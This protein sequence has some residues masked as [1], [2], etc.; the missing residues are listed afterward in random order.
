MTATRSAICAATPRSCVTKMMVMPNS[1]RS[2]RS[3][4]QIPGSARSRRGQWLAR[5][6]AAI[7]G[8]QERASAII[9]RWPK[10][11]RQFVRIGIEPA[12]RR[13]H[14]HEFEQLQRRARAACA[15]PRLMSADRLGNLRTDRID[16]VE[17]R[18]RLL[19]DHRD[20]TAPHVAQRAIRERKHVLSINFDLACEFCPAFR[21]QTHQCAQ[22]HTLAAAGFADDAKDFAC[23]REKL[24]PF[25]ARTGGPSA[26]NCTV[27]SSSRAM[28]SVL[29]GVL[30]RVHANVPHDKP[31]PARLCP[32]SGSWIKHAAS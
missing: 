16:R 26:V 31:V 14:T 12:L 21:Q 30:R 13:G 8:P 17:R 11:T 22:C 29:G 32:D 15:V 28:G 18:H 10:P 7:C 3:S 2:R 20:N 27:S 25:T 4:R 24:T 6:R 23:A 5:R 19:K 1:S 9:A